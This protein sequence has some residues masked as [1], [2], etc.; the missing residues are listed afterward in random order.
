[1]SSGEQYSSKA[2][3]AKSM[4]ATS[5]LSVVMVC[6]FRA[7]PLGKAQNFRTLFPNWEVESQSATS[8]SMSCNRLV[9]K[10]V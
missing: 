6:A 4:E 9:M 8:M 3:V 7:F 1:M 2:G 5:M 10:L